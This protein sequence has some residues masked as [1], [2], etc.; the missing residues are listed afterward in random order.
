MLL[1]GDIGG[2]KTN[3]GIFSDDCVMLAEKTLPSGQYDSLEAL[4]ADFCKQ[5]DLD[6]DRAAFGVAGPVENG[7]AK[8]TN[9]PWQIDE[10]Q[11]QKALGLS[12]AK[13]INDLVA[14]A[15]AV[16]F[17]DS[18]DV[19]TLKTGEPMLH[20]NIA[21]LAPGTGLGEAFLTWG[22]K[23]YQ[24]HASEGG[25]SDFAPTSD[26]QIGLLQ[27]LRERFGHV[28][29]ERVGSGKG[30]PNIYA[31]L[32]ESGVASESPRVVERLKAVD[33]PTPVIVNAALDPDQ[34]CDL[35]S[36]TLDLF[37]G[38]I[39]AEAGNLALK[40]FS[41]GGVYLGGGIPRRILPVLQRDTFIQAF[42][43]KGRMSEVLDRM[44]VKVILNTKAALLGAARFGLAE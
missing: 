16:P 35:C 3:L 29:V 28:S 15:Y 19:V 30:L 10:V 38:I 23:R 11:L 1:A 44:P 8:A 17:L 6:V 34:K 18:E 37:A 12:S 26:V 32:K 13:V 21:I 7:K 43:G 9:L 40:V 42:Q 14:T 41:T 33:D 4:V 2:T 36:A 27:Y 31:Y 24:S 22:G 20:G 39:A 5:V 25:H